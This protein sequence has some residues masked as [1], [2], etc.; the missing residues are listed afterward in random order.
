M[1]RAVF[2]TFQSQFGKVALG[3]DG[4]PLSFEDI[5]PAV[6]R[7]NSIQEGWCDADPECW[8]QKVSLLNAE[9]ARLGLGTMPVYDRVRAADDRRRYLRDLDPA[10]YPRAILQTGG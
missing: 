7:F 5:Q 2:T 10:Q 4:F 9:L 8:P 1:E 3:A 6:E